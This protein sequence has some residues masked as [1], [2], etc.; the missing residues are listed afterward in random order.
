MSP[1]ILQ[2]KAAKLL[3][4]VAM[5]LT[6]T[7]LWA[8]TAEKLI[9]QFDGYAGGNYPIDRPI[10]DDHGNIYGVTQV[11]GEYDGGVAFELTRGS[12][13][14]WQQTVLHNFGAA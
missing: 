7:L 6:S 12:D 14:V 3:F 8:R 2:A 9:F 4:T 1:S 10:F 5:V 13:G 11:G